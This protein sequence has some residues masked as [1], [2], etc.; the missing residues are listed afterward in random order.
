MYTA[1]LI[2]RGGVTADRAVDDTDVRQMQT[3]R[4]D[5]NNDY[6]YNNDD[7]NYHSDDLLKRLQNSGV[8][9]GDGS[10][11]KRRFCRPNYVYNPVSGRCQASLL[12]RN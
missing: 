1:V 5:S 6:Y 8:D 12:V 7:N 3:A 2:G 10:V 9:V 4:R 11:E